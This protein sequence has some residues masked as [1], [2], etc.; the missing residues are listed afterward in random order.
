MGI[1]IRMTPIARTFIIS[2]MENHFKKVAVTLQDAQMEIVEMEPTNIIIFAHKLLQYFHVCSFF[3][4]GFVLN[5]YIE[6]ILGGG[7]TSKITPATSKA[8]GK[9]N[10][11][12]TIVPQTPPISSYNILINCI[13]KNNAHL[14]SQFHFSIHTLCENHTF[15]SYQQ[16]C[17][18]TQYPLHFDKP[19][20]AFS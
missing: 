7:A 13:G 2:P 5:P 17:R 3:E 12:I 14:Y 20:R 15:V 8:T 6:F 4:E 18:N 9:I 10:A 16:H 1:E 19:S 11:T